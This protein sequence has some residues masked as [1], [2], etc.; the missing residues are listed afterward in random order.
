MKLQK[1]LRLITCVFKAGNRFF[2]KIGQSHMKR[3]V[4]D[5][6]FTSRGT[7]PK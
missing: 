7:I 4:F 6:L 2:Y 3:D 1:L 5:H